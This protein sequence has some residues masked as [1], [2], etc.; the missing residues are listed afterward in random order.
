MKV[1]LTGVTGFV[2]REVLKRLL[3]RGDSVRVLVRPQTLARSDGGKQLRQWDGA[4]VVVCDLADA[5]TLLR[6]HQ[7]VEVV[8]HLDWQRE[9]RSPHGRG[10]DLGQINEEVAAHILEACA[11]YNVRRLIF[12]STV[13]VYG[14]SSDMA[15]WPL[16]EETRLYEGS[17][18]RDY[19]GNIVQ[20]KIAIEN[21]IRRAA[22][23]SG[24]EYVIL[25]P[26][27]V[28]GVGWRWA[29]R[30]ILQ[31]LQGV[32][33]IR[34]RYCQAGLQMVHARDMADACVLA[35]IR[36]GAAGREF[37]IAGPEVATIE[38]IM[39]L[40][41]A[42]RFRIFEELPSSRHPLKQRREYQPYDTTKAQTFLG[43]IARVTLRE[44]LAE[45]VAMTPAMPRTA[46]LSAVAPQA[47][48][49]GNVYDQRLQWYATAL[50]DYYGHSDFW[51]WGYWDTRTTNQR[52]ACENLMEKLLSFIPKKQGRIL[53]VAC[54]LGAT[55]RYLLKYY[56]PANVTGI[57]IGEKQL[58][59]CRK[60]APGCTFL[61]MDATELDFRDN[62]FDSII[63]VEAA[64]HFDTREKFVREV[65]RVLKPGGYL[66]LSD[67]LMSRWAP[68]QP[69]ANYTKNLEEY[70]KLFIHA[71]FRNV[72][73]I[74][75][76]EECWKRFAC[77]N[78]R[79]N[80]NK[81]FR[82]EI[83]IGTYRWL[84]AR[85]LMSLQT[86]NYYVLASARK[87]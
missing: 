10:E 9:H 26:T 78:Q 52:E 44:G 68:H 32:R 14:P 81:L 76:T 46:R 3:G 35:G 37:N 59:I 67:I 15:K 85:I 43:F 79:Y 74:D 1:L 18:G 31:A 47:A 28:Y 63:C 39:R 56:R 60:N 86:V 16:N 83:R 75:A 84:V 11:Q 66:V 49:V 7:G 87:P 48:T 24:F 51:N 38:D 27:M 73:I 30:P 77:Y 62:S 50:D 54:G 61:R 71:G 36:P 45:I 58:Q 13:A 72:T 2:G 5:K 53:D 65:Y 12:M 33:G 22:K 69:E 29:D 55:T 25:R 4:D 40:I 70:Q 57:N 21:M 23:E 80:A 17:Y 20:S 8:Y 82:G 6:A 42:V 41:R 19:L 64:F 34:P